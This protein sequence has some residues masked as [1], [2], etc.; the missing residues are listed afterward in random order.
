MS[1]PRLVAAGRVL[2]V[3][4]GLA[5]AAA[6]GFGVV[7]Y[8]TTFGHVPGAWSSPAGPSAVMRDASLL[9]IFALHHSVF[10]RTGVKTLVNRLVTPAF[11]RT[12]YVWLAS[13][14]FASVLLF[15]RPV[16]GVAWTVSL[17]IVS[18]ALYLLQIAGVLFTGYA[19]QQLGVFDLAGLDQAF[20]RARTAPPALTNRGA[21]GFVRHPIYFAWLLMVWPAPFMTGSRLLFAIVTTAYLMLAVPLEERSLRRQFGS[22]YDVY[23]RQVRWR[24]LPGVY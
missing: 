2:A 22:A 4:G 11:E 7:T 21:Y 18:A 9:I 16:P 6:L 23:M 5:F 10:A 13:A 17:P 12:T 20:V 19:S 8:A 1:H 15:W 14:L 24:M 3:L